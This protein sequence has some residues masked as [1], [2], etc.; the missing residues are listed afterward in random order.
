MS[1]L[2][3]AW[4]ERHAQRS[5][6]HTAVVLG[7]DRLSY[8]E[9]DSTSNRIAR[10]LKA[11]GCRKGDRICFSI[12]KS[13]VSLAT[14]LGILK[15]DCIYTPIDPAGP[16]RRAGEILAA[17][18]CSMLLF[19]DAALPLVNELAA[20]AQRRGALVLGRMERGSAK[21]SAFAPAFSLDEIDTLPSGR[22]QSKNSSGD[23]AYILFTSGSTG[24][25]KGV[26]ITHANV[27]AFIDWAVRYFSI[28]MTDRN[29]GHIPLYFDLSVFD[30]FGSLAAGAELHLIPAEYNLFPN[31]LAEFIR[32]SELTQW[33]TVPSTLN[34]MARFDV[35]RH[36]DFPSVKRVVWCGEVL[37]TPSLKYW[38]TRLPARSFTNLYGP[39]EATIASSYYT[40]PECPASEKTEIP[41]G[42]PCDGES[43]L[44][45]DAQM[46]ELPPGEIGDLYIG[47]VGL[48]PGYWNDPARTAEVFVRNTSGS[49]PHERIYRTG[50]LAKKGSDGLIYFAGRADTQIKSRGY[51]IELGEIESALHTIPALVESAVV[52]VTGDGFEGAT[53]CC[54]FVSGG[55]EGVTPLQLRK[56]LSELLPDYMLPSRWMRMDQLPKNANG[57]IDRPAIVESFRQES[58]MMAK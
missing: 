54:A 51:R 9:L 29:S 37:P 26:V 32:S 55:G 13:P 16:A 2:L 28:Q 42:V 50:D 17:C 35:V 44:V 41:I 31:K 21:G 45:L 19:T 27:I 3:Q 38:M 24:K 1:Q 4:P 22:L 56:H 49:G 30:M 10:A 5:P 58:L 14:I 39:T 47:G 40:I 20:D 7:A 11:N 25:P 33:F 43:L 36:N 15:A 48:S 23:P 8:A 18:G 53:I 12:P 6:E 34:L 52:A 57:K 46:K